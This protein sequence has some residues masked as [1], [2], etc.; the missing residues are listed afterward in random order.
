M[1]IGELLYQAGDAE[2]AAKAYERVRG[3]GPEAENAAY[4]RALALAKAGDPA[5]AWE[6]FATHSPLHPKAS[7]AWWTAAREREERK[8]YAGAAKNYERATGP[9]EKA[10]SLYALGRLRERMKQKDLAKAVYLKLKNIS[11]KND[12][13]RLSGLLRLALML[14][15]E[16]KPKQAAP[17]YGEIMRQS[18][19]DSA[20]FETA[21]KRLGALTSDSSLLER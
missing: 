13:A 15:L 4:N 18:D 9:M 19:R 11:P 12:P 2:G 7:W 5:V 1:Q 3:K 16:E 8:D 14:E 21:R 17:L 6:K 20:T 10:K